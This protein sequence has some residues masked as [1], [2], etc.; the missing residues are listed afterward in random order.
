MSRLQKRRKERPFLV[1][2]FQNGG[3]V[4]R[5]DRAEGERTYLSRF[6]AKVLQAPVFISFA[7]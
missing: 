2:L 6:L 1:L 7:L 3:E 4:T 5:S